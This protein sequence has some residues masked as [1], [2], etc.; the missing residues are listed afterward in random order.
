MTNKNEKKSILWLIVD[1]YKEIIPNLQP[2]S[3]P[4]KYQN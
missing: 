3:E 4:M 2:E 1:I